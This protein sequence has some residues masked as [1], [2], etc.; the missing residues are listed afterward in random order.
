VQNLFQ[1]MKMFALLSGDAKQAFAAATAGSAQ[2]IGLGAEIGRIEPGRKA[3]IT[4]LSLRDPAFAPLNDAVRQ[5][6]YTEPGRSVRHVIVDGRLVIE[7]GRAA[8]LD[9]DALYADIERLMPALLRDLEAIR[10]RNESLMPHVE[11]ANR[12]TRALDVGVERY[13]IIEC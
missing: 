10:Q 2:A 8:L 4:L 9:E 12:R 13:K 7:H 11:E 1:A 3:D 5:L 6:V